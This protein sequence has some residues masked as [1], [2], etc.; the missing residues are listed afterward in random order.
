MRRRGDPRDSRA[1]ALALA[2]HAMG[3]PQLAA[4][5]GVDKALKLAVEGCCG[6]V[7]ERARWGVA[8]DREDAAAGWAFA[9]GWRA[10]RRRYAHWYCPRCG[11][12]AA[13]GLWGQW[14]AGAAAW[15]GWCMPCHLRAAFPPPR[16][17]PPLPP[18]NTLLHYASSG[19]PALLHFLRRLA[20]AA[21]GD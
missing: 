1:L 18:D 12:L 13:R 6:W 11:R 14:D 19:P 5:R 17:P 7:V 3:L 2:L 21:S 10:L 15:L 4:L 16:R 20:A 8:P 9:A